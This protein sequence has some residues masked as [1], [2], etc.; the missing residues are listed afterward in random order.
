MWTPEELRD[1]RRLHI[2]AGRRVDSAF[3]GDWRSAM[4]GQGMEFDQVR[5]YVAGDDVRHIDWNVTAR[6]NEPHVKVFREERQVTVQ[7]VV[8][9]SGSTIP[10]SGGRDGRTDRRL[11]IARIAGSLAFAALRNRDRLGL[12]TWTDQEE[13]YLPPGASRS[14]GWAVLQATYAGATRGRRTDLASAFAAVAKRQ[15]RRAVV[16]VVSDFFDE[17]N[18]DRGLANLARRHTVHAILV[19]DPLDEAPR[20]GLVDVVDPETGAQVLVD[21]AAWSARRSTQA[22]LE[23]IRRT[24]A[25][26]VALSTKDDAIAV[27]QRWFREQ[28]RA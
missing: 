7:L 6:A 3:S 4:R 27:L 14:H 22:R 18:W 20:L 25:R 26:A 2:V 1:L 10:G 15:R 23:R 28:V 17:G 16:A 8:D 9:V 5:P 21:T 24:G 12:L 19:H 11:Q 13:A